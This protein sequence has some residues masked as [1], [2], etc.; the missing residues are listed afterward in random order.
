MSGPR[1]SLREERRQGSEAIGNGGVRESKAGA[2]TVV[3]L[4]GSQRAPE[5]WRVVELCDEGVA[6]HVSNG[7]EAIV[8]GW[9][10]L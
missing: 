8:R 4:C 1:A 6:R 10:R 5:S 9:K 3:P 7:R 2:E